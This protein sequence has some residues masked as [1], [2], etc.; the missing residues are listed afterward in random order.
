MKCANS[1][2]AVTVLIII[3]AILF[4]ILSGAALFFL[5]TEMDKRLAVEE[6]L[7]QVEETKA[8]IEQK[9]A[10]SDSLIEQLSAKLREANSTNDIL[11]QELDTAKVAFDRL[12]K[13]NSEIRDSLRKEKSAKDDALQDLSKLQDELETLKE[14]LRKAEETKKELEGQ[15]Q[16][17]RIGQEEVQL[18][19]I[20]VTPEAI[21][22]DLPDGKVM[23][24]NKEHDFIIIDLGGRDGMGQG[25]VFTVLQNNKSIG[26]V[27][28]EKVE[29]SMSVASFLDE[30]VRSKVKQDDI[31]K[32]KR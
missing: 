6:K 4:F 12:D 26:E 5:K 25:L 23:V 2:K 22:E 16:D 32:I 29:E 24:V 17:L 27:I 13:D 9:L 10:E 28:I 31:V 1:G 19:K 20:V 14:Q 15:V 11:I 21:P 3:L 18:E 8:K 7:E 30:G